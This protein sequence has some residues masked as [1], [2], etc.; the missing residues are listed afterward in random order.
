MHY[1]FKHIQ[2]GDVSL[3]YVE[4]GQ[5]VPLVL[6]HGSGPTDLRTWG[7]QIE[8]FAE[9]YRVIA[10][11]RRYHYPN[12]W[13]D[14]DSAVLS[15][16]VHANDLAALITALQLGRVHLVGFSYGAD[17]A[18]RFAVEHPEL[19]RTL[20]VGEPGLNSWL[21]TLPG[22]ASLFAESAGALQAAKTEVQNGNFERSLQLFMDVVMGIGAFDQ[23]PLA[24]YER[25]MAN[26]RLIGY[27]QTEI[28]ESV[29]DITRAEAATIRTPTLMLTG[30]KSPEA[31]W[32]VSQELARWI[33]HAEQ[34]QIT[35][36]SHL[37]H[38]M[39][40][41]DYNTAVLKFLAGHETE[42]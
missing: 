19:L 38:V 9:H 26:V 23:I 30:D 28:S 8:P 6:L 22:G 7:Q 13:I 21:V 10:Y 16:F 5:G 31:F 4:R 24:L 1:D 12:T 20:V 35:G 14:D 18:L 3:A 27:E 34:A 11:S 29:T 36:A 15:T 32:L 17:I 37:L 39:N 25:L 42:G 41:T 2:A 40:P 33:P